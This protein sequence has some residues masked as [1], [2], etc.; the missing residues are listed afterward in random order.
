MKVLFI[1]THNSARSQMA[2]GLLRH[3]Y[4][5]RFEAY[6]AGITPTKVQ[7]LAVRVVA[8]LGIDISHHR[9]KSTHEFKGG[10]FDVAVTV[11]DEAKEACP[12]FPGALK[13]LHWSFQDPSKAE[14]RE[15]EI[16]EVFRKVRDEIKGRI[17]KAVESGELGNHHDKKM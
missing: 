10:E 17:I 16:L 9:A 15:E 5:D 8:E 4:G 7:P 13:Q 6:S 2:E 3:L 12:L 11:C 14:G 1:C